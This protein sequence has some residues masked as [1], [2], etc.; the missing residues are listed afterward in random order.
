MTWREA[1]HSDIPNSGNVD[2][3]HQRWIDLEE[4]VKSHFWAKKQ[5]K[6]TEKS[7]SAAEQWVNRE[8]VDGQFNDNMTPGEKSAWYSP[9][10]A[11]VVSSTLLSQGRVREASVGFRFVLFFRVALIFL[12]SRP[13]RLLRTAEQMGIDDS[14]ES[15]SSSPL[16]HHQIPQFRGFRLD[17]DLTNPAERRAEFPIE[18]PQTVRV[19]GTHGTEEEYAAFIN[20]LQ[21]ALPPQNHH[22]YNLDHAAD[23]DEMRHQHNRPAEPGHLLE[24]RSP[25]P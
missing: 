12:S 24:A 15:P 3:D 18:S 13:R 23:G 14:L 21:G 22:A 25:L 10:P 6:A 2:G 7:S 5:K 11:R 16:G 17:R 8:R 20:R 1:Q 4:G 9:R 19:A